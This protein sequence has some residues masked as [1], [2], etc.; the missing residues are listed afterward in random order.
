MAVNYKWKLHSLAEFGSIGTVAV[1]GMRCAV[2]TIKA[3]R[4]MDRALTDRAGGNVI[5]RR[6]ERKPEGAHG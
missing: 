5:L 6:F 4:F 2:E 3:L 1:A